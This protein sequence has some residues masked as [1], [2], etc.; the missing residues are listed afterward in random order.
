MQQANFR[1]EKELWGKGMK[2]VAGVDEVGRG[3]WAGPLYTAAVVF[4]SEVKLPF[5]LFDSKVLSPKKRLEL[6]TLVKEFA[7][8]FAFGRAEVSLIERRGISYATEY[9]MRCA[10]NGLSS[11]PDFVLVDY[12]RISSL[13]RE[14]YQAIKKGDRYSA[15]IA[16]ASIIAKVER[17]ARM[18]DFGQSYP[19]YGFA[20]HK[21]YGTKA[22]QEAIQKYGSTKIH[23]RSF[24]PESCRSF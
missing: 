17:D 2:L 23:R 9:A 19:A 21:G 12:F 4:P 11:E 14:K 22:H 3:A 24:I 5:S 16:A 13:A 8:S 18:S 10:L 15:T 20:S 1:F 7:L 6:S